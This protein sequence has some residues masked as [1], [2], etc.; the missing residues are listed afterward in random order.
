MADIRWTAS[1]AEHAL[2]PVDVWRI[3]L[4]RRVL[5]KSRLVSI[6]GTPRKRAGDPGKLILIPDPLAEHPSYFEVDVRDIRAF[7][8]VMVVCD[9]AGR[10]YPI[11]RAWFDE[12]TVC[13]RSEV[14][15]LQKAR[16]PVWSLTV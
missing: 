10:S 13:V 2:V 14:V 12:G 1:S 3:V 11:I 16:G 15:V 5:D 9:D 8:D 7:D 4:S 6:T